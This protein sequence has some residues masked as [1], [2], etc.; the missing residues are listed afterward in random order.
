M[1]GARTAVRGRVAPPGTPKPVGRDRAAS[2]AAGK[3][4]PRATAGTCWWP[5]CWTSTPRSRD[6]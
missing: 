6:P 3:R 5:N 2:E 1:V 4:S